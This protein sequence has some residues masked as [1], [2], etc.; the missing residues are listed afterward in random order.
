MYPFAI[1]ARLLVDLAVCWNFRA[2]RILAPTELMSIYRQGCVPLRLV[3]PPL[4]VA[5]SSFHPAKRNL[6]ICHQLEWPFFIV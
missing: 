6:K 5:S 3:G 4:P 1:R 2:L